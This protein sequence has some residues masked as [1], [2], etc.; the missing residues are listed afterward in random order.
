MASSNHNFSFERC[1]SL[2]EI[3]NLRNQYLN[4]LIEPQELYLELMV[5]KS[6]A[7]IISLND[8]IIGYFLISDDAVLLEYFIV[9]K[10]VD[11]AD[12]IFNLILQRFSIRTA[13]CKSFDHMLLSC[14]M[15][16][17]KKTRVL[18]ILFRAYHPLSAA[19]KITDVT[20]RPAE[21]EDE[22]HIIAINEEVFDHDHEV[23]EYIHK[24]QLLIFEKDGKNIGFGI[25][26]RIIEGRPDFDIG[27]LV[28]KEFRRQGVGQITISYL[29]DYCLKNGWRPVAG[30]AVENIGSRRCL[31][32]AGFIAGYRLL[33]FTF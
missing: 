6:K 19:D 17:Q 7:Y 22:G 12:A 1:T 30:C 27:M 21:I 3:S 8:E 29:A 23:L 5:R 14:C 25:F 16:L 31:E 10:S 9:Q 11:L 32:N 28:E 13:L 15:S 4:E 2:D 33:E 18:G 24:K 26:S 20:I